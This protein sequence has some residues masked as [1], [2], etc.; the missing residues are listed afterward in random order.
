MCGIIGYLGP[1]PI[2][3]V[4]L[5]ALRHL[6]YRGYDSAGLAILDDGVFHIHRSSGKLHNLERMV[7]GREISGTVG[8]GHTRWATHGG[9]TEE[10]AHP[11]QAGDVV[12]VHNGIIENY[13]ELKE[14][15]ARQGRRFTSE[16][17]TEIIAHLIDQVMLEEP[18]SFLEAVRKAISRIRGSFACGIM[19]RKEPRT[20]IA[21][22][23]ASPLIVGVG[24]GES[25]FASDIPA[26]LRYTQR[27]VFL[28][29]GQ[30]ARITEGGIEIFTLEGQPVSPT[31]HTI[32]WN[33][34]MAEKGGHKHFMLKEIHEQ[35]TA[36]I[37]TIE[38]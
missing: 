16:T 2:T 36:I 15:L 9:P 37:H 27:V 29:D 14:G 1:R 6:E 4:L 25:F 7:A 31:L 21:V 18:V 38:G 8:L 17:D 30:L 13:L 35:P 12:L 34:V 28:E 33:P 19:H 3:E 26:L 24:E 22:K 20:L 32:P 5:D 11:H 23:N 10:N